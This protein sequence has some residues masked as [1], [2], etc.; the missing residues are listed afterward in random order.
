MTTESL[1]AVYRDLELC[2]R[3]G[4]L[5]GSVEWTDGREQRHLEQECACQRA[6]RSDAVP[7]WWGFDFNVV[8]EL[9]LV[10]ETE[11][12]ASG[13]RFA[14][15][16]CD[17]CRARGLRVHRDQRLEAWSREA[18]FRNLVDAGLAHRSIVPLTDYLEVVQQVD[19]GQRVDECITFLD[20]RTVID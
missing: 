10:C 4:E 1:Q 17:D 6:L 19:R 11:V 5:R 9:C 2:T 8:A 18:L 14:A 7:R 20:L 16:M 12:V 15:P 13:T 3:C